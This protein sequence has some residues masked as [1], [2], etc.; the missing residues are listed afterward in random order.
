MIAPIGERTQRW[1]LL[2]ITSTTITSGFY[3]FCY[4]KYLSWKYRVYKGQMKISGAGTDSVLMSIIYLFQQESITF[5]ASFA[6]FIIFLIVLTF[7]IKTFNTIS[8][9]I[10]EVEKPK[11]EQQR[12]IRL[13][14]RIY[15][16]VINVYDKGFIGNWLECLFPRRPHAEK[17]KIE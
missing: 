15:D 5:I 11:Y 2:F 16:P 14:N 3:T 7:T 4:Y 17:E 8:N 12:L 13:H 9:N 6:L 1:F 10:L